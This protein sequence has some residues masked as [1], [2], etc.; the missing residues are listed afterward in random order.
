MLSQ[1]VA[2]ALPASFM[3]MPSVHPARVSSRGDSS[4][5]FAARRYPVGS[6]TRIIISP[7]SI[8]QTCACIHRLGN[9]KTTEMSPAGTHGAETPPARPGYHDVDRGW[10]RGARHEGRIIGLIDIWRQPWPPPTRVV[11]W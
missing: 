8:V 4:I 3:T 9:C 10:S 11:I 6:R 5:D 7:L 1:F 2:S